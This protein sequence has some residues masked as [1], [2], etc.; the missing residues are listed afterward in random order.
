[1]DMSKNKK[2]DCKNRKK[3]SLDVLLKFSKSSNINN[4]TKRIG[5]PLTNKE[6]FCCKNEKENFY[7]KILK[8]N[9]L[10]ME[11]KEIIKNIPKEYLPEIEVDFSKNIYGEMI[12]N[13]NYNPILSQERKKLE[14][15]TIPYSNNIL[16]LYIDSVSRANSIRQ[17]KKTM[18]F[19]AQFM[20]YKQKLNK[21]YI[22][23]FHSFQF[24]K[25][26]SFRG[27]TCI[28]YPIIFY[29]KN[30]KK[31]NKERITKYFKKNRF[32]TGLANDICYR[33][34][35]TTFHRMKNDEVYDYQMLI[36]DPNKLSSLEMIKRCLYGKNLIEHLF[37]YAT[38][39]WIKYKNNRKF[40]FVLSHEGHEGTLER[41]KYIDEFI[42]NFLNNLYNESLLKDSSILLI[43]DHGVGMPSIYSIN[44]FYK[45]EY[46][47]PM[48]YMII[49]DRENKTYEE[50]YKFIHKNQQTLITGYD[51]YYTLLHLI[52]GD[53]FYLFNKN[54][55]KNSTNSKLGISLFI[56]I[57]QKL[58]TTKLYNMKN[59]IVCV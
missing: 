53:K 40:F 21:F 11:N 35:T 45:I 12:I 19:I 56:E 2:I 25:Y 38:Q 59:K 48:L 20:P 50:Q 44:D 41:L 1:M 26:H 9:L 46:S 18:K 58:R 31:G 43:S 39:F 4:K 16:L 13:L 7:R 8:Y 29:N 34:G 3:N 10:D 24:F 54:Y 36:C 55:I 51:I 33:D 17:L 14:I 5:F 57:N 22:G 28:N 52:Y 27:Y 37:E 32:I 47:L 6:P 15:N 23:N 42:F 30:P 49:N